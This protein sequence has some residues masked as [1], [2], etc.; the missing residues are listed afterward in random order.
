MP[1][2]LAIDY[3]SKRTGIAVTDPMQ[4][5]ASGLR[6]VQT[7]ELLAFLKDYLNKEE[8][9]TFVIGQPFRLD[10]RPSDIEAEILKFI[11]KLQLQHPIIPIK[12]IDETYTSK[13]AFQT[14]IDS[15]VKKKKRRDKSLLDSISATLILQDYLERL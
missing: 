1:R 12:R 15:G 8:V 13:I 11:T 5:I 14:L 9:E 3:G 6:T 4:I 10:G 7:A 2:I